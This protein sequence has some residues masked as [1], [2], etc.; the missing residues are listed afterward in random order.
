MPTLR[1]AKIT[2]RIGKVQ[3][4]DDG[5]KTMTTDGTKMVYSWD[6]GKGEDI[7]MLAFLFRLEFFTLKQPF[8]YPYLSIKVII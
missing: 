7:V 3:V 4:N 5:T 2:G 1:N 6:D 8:Y